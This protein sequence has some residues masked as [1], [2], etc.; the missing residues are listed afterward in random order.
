M[1]VAADRSG[2]VVYPEFM[3]FNSSLG[4]FEPVVVWCWGA[5]PFAAY[6]AA[7]ALATS[8]SMDL[9]PSPKRARATAASLFAGATFG[10]IVGA[11][12]LLAPMLKSFQAL[13]VLGVIVALTGV[14][15]VVLLGFPIVTVL[16]A[17][18]FSRPNEIW[19]VVTLTCW[20]VVAFWL[21]TWIWLQLRG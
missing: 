19:R 21:E 17:S 10:V 18:K 15:L 12:G 4:D 2:A 5:G 6:A 13:M 3:S 1:R 8:D 14:G 7:M 11:L 16:L 9:L 20:A